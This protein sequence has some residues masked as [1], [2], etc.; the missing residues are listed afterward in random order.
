[1]FTDMF[2]NKRYKI[3][4][5]THTTVSDGR[6]SPEEAAR[7]YHQ[8]GYDAIALTDHWVLSEGGIIENLPILAGCEYNFGTDPS[9]DPVYHIL[10]LLPDRDPGVQRSDSPQVCIDKII[11]AGGISVQLSDWAE[12]TETTESSDEIILI[13]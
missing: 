2:G 5:H 3:N 13:E 8:S 1:M 9:T 11:N 4:L 7:V 6:V 10:A 12:S